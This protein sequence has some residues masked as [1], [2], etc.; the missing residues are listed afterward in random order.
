M[1]FE[2]LGRRAVACKGW[3]WMPGMLTTAGRQVVS[4]PFD[5]L[6]LNN[7]LAPAVWVADPDR[8]MRLALVEGLLPD[9]TDPATALLLLALVREAWPI[10]PERFGR[11]S[12]WGKPMVQRKWLDGRPV[13][14]RVVDDGGGA[15]LGRGATEAEALVLALEGRNWGWW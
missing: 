2:E 5:K 10:D 1:D 9:L 11:P 4:K 15:V 13:E 7:T 6:L 14:W 8:Q 3:R 12:T